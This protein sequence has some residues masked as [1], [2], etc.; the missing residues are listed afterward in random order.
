MILDKRRAGVLLHLTSLPCK[1][2]Y[3]ALNREAMNF[4]DFLAECKLSLWQMLPIHPTHG[5]SH[6][7]FLSPYQCQSVHA[8]NP[9]LISL[10]VLA[11]QEIV[12]R[13]RPRFK[14]PEDSKQLTEY[15]YESLKVAYHYFC[16]FC[17]DTTTVIDHHKFT[18][19]QEE[20]KQ[21]LEDYA[22]FRVL[23]EK[24]EHRPW[25]E[26]D[27]AYRDKD[28]QALA[29]IQ[30]ECQSQ[31][32]QQYYEQFL[33]FQ[34]WDR[35]K[36][37][38]NNRGV[39][40]VGDMPFFVAEDSVEMWVYRDNFLLND[41]GRAKYFAG[42]N[43]QDDYFKPG[44]G[45]CWKLPV[46]NWDHMETNNFQW[47]IQRFNTMSCLFDMVRLAHFR[48]YVRTWAIPSETSDP[49]DGFWLPAHGEK[50]FERL[51]KEWQH[52][53]PLMVDDIGVEKKRE[54]DVYDLWHEKFRVEDG[55]GKIQSK[56]FGMKVLQLG[57]TKGDLRNLH[58][59]HHYT[60]NRVAYTGTYDSDTT[61]GW[62]NH[63]GENRKFVFD[64]FNIHE[65][66]EVMSVL[67]RYVIQSPAYFAIIPMQDILRLDG[68]HRMNTPGEVD[69][70]WQ[71]QFQ[72]TQLTN[73][74]KSE[75]RKL[76]EWYQRSV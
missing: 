67:I 17:K 68:E 4:V 11:D 53:I 75:L 70:C 1:Y 24:F 65:Q 22:L 19:F 45:Q 42:T 36:N 6:P 55:S 31:L 35:L 66:D 29:Q 69:G 54:R 61:L 51:K 18:R 71:W 34:Q 10:Q 7:D 38:A 16:N 49:K 23:K 5:L 32:E 43:P 47:W 58:L 26:W 28:P 8:G 21:W 14:F 72:W 76:V 30:Q 46:Y 33:F 48:G 12:T 64:Y 63:L 40:L 52:P 50:M 44:E 73:P 62:L 74:M 2:G 37:Y 27:K 39:Y 57:F 60:P 20:N 3:G 25:W 9:L 15:R 59:P 56:M 41:Q 13:N